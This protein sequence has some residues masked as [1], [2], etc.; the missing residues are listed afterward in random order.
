LNLERYHK[1]DNNDP[2]V[3]YSF[4]YGGT[5]QVGSTIRVQ[6]RS[7]RKIAVNGKKDE[8]KKEEDRP[9]HEDDKKE[10]L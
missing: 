7:E 6:A 10:E 2:A 9:R 1:K 8:K 3:K 5:S 4:E